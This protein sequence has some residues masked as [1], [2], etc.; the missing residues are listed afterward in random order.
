[1]PQLPQD[2]IACVLHHVSPSDRLTSCA[3]VCKAWHAT[4][5]AST[6]SMSLT[7]DR[8]VEANAAFSWLS[9]HG[10]GVSS[11]R[12]TVSEAAERLC[13]D[14]DLQVWSWLKDLRLTGQ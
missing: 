1:V 10:K 6:T 7:C 11:V 12:I 4:C 5:C 9:K 2:L 8:Q 3:L 14:C 13:L